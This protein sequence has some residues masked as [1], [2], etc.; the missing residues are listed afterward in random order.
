[1]SGRDKE[2]AIKAI[3]GLLQSTARK[4]KEEQAEQ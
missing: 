3:H 4:S 1:M 2:A